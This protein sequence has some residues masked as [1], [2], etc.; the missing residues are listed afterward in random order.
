MQN[1]GFTILKSS[2][3][4]VVVLAL[5]LCS[6]TRV[7]AT[8]V[9]A[10]G[11]HAW[12]VPDT[13]RVATGIVP[14]TLNPLLSS[15][16]SELAIDRLFDD[17]LVTVDQHGRFVP[18]LAAEVPTTAN[19]GISADGRTIR[20][21]LREHVRWQDGRPFTSADVKFTYDA[22]MNPQNDVVSRHGYDVVER[23]ET[24]D[25]D[26]VIFHLKQRFAP[27]VATVFGESDGPFCLLPAHLFAHRSSINDAPYNALP[28][29][30][31]PFRVV[32]WLRGNRI[33]LVRNDDY[34]MGRP[35]LKS[36]VISFV[37][38]E[39]AELVELR[40][41]EIDWA[42][43]VSVNAYR[44]LR[45]MS[46]DVRSVLTPFNGYEAIIFN[47]AHG[48]TSDVRIRRAI[49]Y[50]LDKRALVD[51]LAFGA[52]E[53]ATEDLPPFLW[54]YDRTLR[55]TPY[56]VGQAKGL[57]AAAGYGP[58]RRL[59]LNL[60][61][62]QSEAANRSLGVQI[63]SLLAPL[64]IDVTLHPQQSSVYYASYAEHGTLESG[65]FDLALNRWM[66]GIDPDDSAQFTCNNIPPK[67]VNPPHFCDPAM[68]AAQTIAL[69][70]YGEPGR[71]P[72]YA[73]I[74]RILEQ[75]APQDFLW[76]PKQIEAI[77]P[78]L[79]GF[80][81]NPVTETWNAWTWSI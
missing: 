4:L 54:A 10:I 19:G 33:E 39:N 13:L 69:E 17:L 70:T 6:C 18:D 58:A 7:P 53:P 42:F 63:Q 41:H 31:G 43:Q 22:I 52:A 32:R 49:T 38:D 11:R 65:A 81:P 28:I 57:L 30:T 34:F 45:S 64:G 55:A 37:P 48:P 59:A 14:R 36:I 50:A 76:W 71:T 21:R 80:A 74:Q 27:F 5:L 25:A 16:T 12:T 51:K 26:T 24:P 46:P 77:S 60:Y 20:Y 2:S 75:Q 72:A 61:F 1:N 23:V 66:S 35:K 62:E 68:D 56:D 44:S 73:R 8:G 78:D 9:Q 40:T 47:A 67:G 3:R 29:G 79:R 15:E